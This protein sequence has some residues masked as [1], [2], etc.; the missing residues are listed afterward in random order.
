MVSKDPL[1]KVVKLPII[2]QKPNLYIIY[3][4]QRQCLLHPL[5]FYSYNIININEVIQVLKV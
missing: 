1:G 2:V 3:P 5:H 4:T